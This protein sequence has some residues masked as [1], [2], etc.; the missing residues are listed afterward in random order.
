MWVVCTQLLLC[1]RGWGSR[2]TWGWSRD[3]LGHV[4][5][6]GHVRLMWVT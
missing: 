2:D 6:V 3:K 1:M 5:C 4:M